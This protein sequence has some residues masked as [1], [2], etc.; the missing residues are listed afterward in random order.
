MTAFLGWPLGV[1]LSAVASTIGVVGKILLKLS[2]QR[3]GAGRLLWGCGMLC[4]VALNPFLCISAYNFAPQ[5]LLAP[6]GGLCVVWNTVF[7]PWILDE[8]LRAR[9]IIGAAC[10]F[11]GCIVV[12]ITGGH[13]THK[14][15]VDELASHFLSVQFIVYFS[16]F[17]LT[18]L[19]LRFYSAAA[20]HPSRA[21]NGSLPHM[22]VKCRVCLSILAGSLSGQLYC[23]TALLRLLQNGVGVLFTTPLAYAVG[24]GAIFFALSGLH[25]LSMALQLYDALFVIYLYESTLMAVGAISGI[26]F[27]GDMDNVSVLR[28]VLYFVGIGTIFVGVGVISHGESLKLRAKSLPI[29]KSDATQTLLA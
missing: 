24:A 2:F 18:S 8:P 11:V 17:V 20:F 5:S 25:L 19:I 28:W 4:I 14:I 3:P 15:P 29:E 23:M 7:S 6:M 27:F 21:A 1:L 22:H 13:E 16:L 12:S 10:I 26:C 9:D